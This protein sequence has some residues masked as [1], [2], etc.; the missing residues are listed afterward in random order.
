MDGWMDT[1]NKV[2]SSYTV[3]IEP[4]LE[5][6]F[7]LYRFSFL[8][9]SMLCLTLLT[10][11]ILSWLHISILAPFWFCIQHLGLCSLHWVF[12][13]FIDRPALTLTAP[14]FLLHSIRLFSFAI[15]KCFLTLNGDMA[16]VAFKSC[17]EF[18]Q[19]GQMYPKLYLG[20]WMIWQWVAQHFC[21]L[22]FCIQVSVHLQTPIVMTS[23][24]NKTSESDCDDKKYKQKYLQWQVSQGNQIR[25][26]AMTSK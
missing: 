26:I 23:N 11:S 14:L 21:L 2:C 25:T 24:P 20:F 12:H 3:A 9:S 13:S 18:F 1:A 17:C 6:D 22:K 8:F 10:W 16:L 4:L 7:Y 19:L 5:L 15:S